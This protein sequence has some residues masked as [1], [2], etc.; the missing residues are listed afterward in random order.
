M[1]CHF[2]TL[3]RGNGN[4][5]TP[6]S[7]RDVGGEQI[8]AKVARNKQ[9]RC[10]RR[11]LD[12]IYKH[13]QVQHYKFVEATAMRE[14][15]DTSYFFLHILLLWGEKVRSQASLAKFQTLGRTRSERQHP[16]W[17]IRRR[18]LLWCRSRSIFQSSDRLEGSVGKRLHV[19]TS[20]VSSREASSPG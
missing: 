8:K 7:A 6:N 19:S 17:R 15:G 5:Q 9:L 1:R 20:S 4:T 12:F 18:S 13:S 2:S 11:D 14:G 3:S 16:E 10:C